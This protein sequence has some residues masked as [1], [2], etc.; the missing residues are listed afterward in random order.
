M[1]FSYYLSPN[2]KN[3]KNQIF[4]S[5]SPEA[6]SDYS[7]HF[8]TPFYINTE[9]WDHV[10]KR[11]KNIYCKEFKQLNVKLNSIKIE[12]VQLIQTKKLKNKAP[13]SRAISEIIKKISIDE[14]QKK[15]SEESLLHMTSQ[16]LDAKKETLCLSTYRRYLVFFRLIEKFESFITQH[17]LLQDVNS[18]FI[19]SFYSFGKSEQYSESTIKRT[20]EFVKTILNYAERMGLATHV[21]NLEIPKNKNPKRVITL[22]EKELKKIKQTEVPAD[23]QIAKD[24]LLISCYTG[25]RISDFMRFNS[26]QLINING[27]ICISFIQQKTGKEIILPLHPTVLDILAKNNNNFPKPLDR[28]LYNKHIKEIADLSG[29]KEFVNTRKRIGFRS[30]EM[31]IE[32]FRNISSHIGRRSFASNFYGKIPT[33]LLMQATGHS[34]EKIFLNY[35]N[36]VNHE[37]IMAL[38]NYFEEIYSGKQKK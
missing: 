15:Y 9:D 18:E 30:R 1:T 38:G 33:P 12:L 19:Q 20:V 4:L 6:E 5:F 2:I 34:S 36:P 7:Y 28:S 25:Q 29:I 21:R 31:Q 32:K 23:L 14:Q 37:G 26:N 3:R 22:N 24:W 13:S 35:I 16:Y 11:P 10:K 27:K 17:I 8:T